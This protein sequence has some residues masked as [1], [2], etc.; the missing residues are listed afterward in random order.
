MINSE[1]DLK[2]FIDENK[3]SQV[4]ESRVEFRPFEPSK[5]IQA[6]KSELISQINQQKLVNNQLIIENEIRMSEIDE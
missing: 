4:F 2:I 6:Q 1:T 5:D 3:T